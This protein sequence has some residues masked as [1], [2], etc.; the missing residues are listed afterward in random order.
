MSLRRDATSPRLRLPRWLP[1]DLRLLCVTLWLAIDLLGATL[2]LPACPRAN[3]M[4]M[5]A[6][7]G[8]T[9]REMSSL[10]GFTAALVVMQNLVLNV[11][12]IL[13]VFSFQIVWFF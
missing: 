12:S 7:L 8:Y 2:V 13:F 9:L 1:V 4:G 10:L 6:D 3:P 11:V 5:T